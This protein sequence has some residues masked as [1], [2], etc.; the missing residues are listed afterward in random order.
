MGVLNA[1][2]TG[3]AV[4]TLLALGPAARRWLPARLMAVTGGALVAL[5]AVQAAGGLPLS[6]GQRRCRPGLG[7]GGG[8]GRGRAWGDSP[9]PI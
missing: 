7:R 8:A 9:D 3:V 5:A 1:V 2:L 4:V 6:A